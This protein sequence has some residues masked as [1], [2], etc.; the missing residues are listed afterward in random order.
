MKGRAS[1]VVNHLAIRE[2][3]EQTVLGT[4]Q[5]GTQPGGNTLNARRANSS[6]GKGGGVSSTLI[7][8]GSD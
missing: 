3:K 8:R 6:E 7:L 2:R 4:A 1:A 5:K